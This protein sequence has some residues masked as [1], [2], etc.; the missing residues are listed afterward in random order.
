MLN[1]SLQ[2]KEDLQCTK[3]LAHTASWIYWCISSDVACVV[4]IYWRN[5]ASCYQREWDLS[6]RVRQ[7]WISQKLKPIGHADEEDGVELPSKIVNED[8]RRFFMPKKYAEPEPLPKALPEVRSRPACR[9]SN[10]ASL[11]LP[12]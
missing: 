9:S 6:S 11:T 1:K 10:A 8:L 5:L 2:S 7:K 3:L 4:G 12:H